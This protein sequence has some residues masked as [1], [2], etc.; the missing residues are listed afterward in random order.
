[1]TCA[2]K[3]EF[4]ITLNASFTC[5]N[6]LCRSCCRQSSAH[7][8]RRRAGGTCATAAWA[9]ARC[10]CRTPLHGYAASASEGCADTQPL[11]H[12]H[13]IVTHRVTRPPPFPRWQLLAAASA[14]SSRRLRDSFNICCGRSSFF[15]PDAA[16]CSRL[17]CPRS[18]SSSSRRPG[19][20]S[21]CGCRTAAACQCRS[22]A[23]ASSPPAAAAG[24]PR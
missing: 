9:A 5:C 2:C 11:R 19:G 15:K 17:A 1:M 10:L 8:G 7:R 21:R 24:P 12:I 6:P 16:A 3:V 22:R 18:S 4:A 13:H 20:G 14:A 23:P